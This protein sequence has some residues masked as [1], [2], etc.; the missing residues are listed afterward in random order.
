MASKKVE[1]CLKKNPPEHKYSVTFVSKVGTITFVA[2]PI[3]CNNYLIL[4]VFASVFEMAPTKSAKRIKL[5]SN[6]LG[7]LL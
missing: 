5:E 3:I 4:L 7:N 6:F 2:Y 1:I